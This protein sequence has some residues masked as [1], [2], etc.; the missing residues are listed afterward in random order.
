MTGEEA[1]KG[2]IDSYKIELNNELTRILQYWLNNTLD[3]VN[4]GFYGRIS[5]HNHVI[6]DAPKGSVI[7]ARILWSFSSAYNFSPNPAHLETANRA[8]RYIIH[9]FID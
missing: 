5:N 8:Y 1:I 9:H 2:Q 3:E 6:A 4:G 7:N